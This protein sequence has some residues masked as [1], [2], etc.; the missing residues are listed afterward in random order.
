MP[1]SKEEYVEVDQP[2]DTEELRNQVM[3]GMLFGFPQ[4]DIHVPDELIDKFSKFCPLFVVDSIP[5]ELIPS[6]MREYQ[7]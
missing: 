6:H 5:G 2:Y 4:V 1:C 7:N 3:K